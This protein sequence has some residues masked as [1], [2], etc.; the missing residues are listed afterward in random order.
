MTVFLSILPIYGVITLGWV[1]RRTGFLSREADDTLFRL[2]VNVLY[3]CLVFDAILGNPSLRDTGAL[4]V[5]PFLGFALAAG[6]MGLC[7]MLAGAAGVEGSSSRGTFALATGMFN[8]AYLALP[9]VLALF[10]KG[11]AGV[12]FVF[13]VGVEV[14]MWTVGRMLLTE[15]GGPGMWRKMVNAPVVAVFLALA[16]N[17]LNDGAW[18]PDPLRD[19]IHLVGLASIPI[20]LLLVGAS[21][22][23]FFGEICWFRQRREL[24]SALVLR[25]GLLPPLFLAVAV[26]LPLSRE[27][28]E[29]IVVQAAMP[30]AVFPLVM[31]RLYGGDAPLALLVILGTTLGSLATMPFWI[32]WG[33]E[34]VGKF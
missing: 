31:A 29:V 26:C 32:H 25:L 19:T 30:S 5:A 27:L 34:L 16:A 18:V 1:L 10:G 23:D 21:F 11:A 12:L 28:R 9:I 15:K 6:G 14:A 4:V 17:A 33:M 3:P 7:R 20:G 24:A 8:W 22:F 2:S 13:N